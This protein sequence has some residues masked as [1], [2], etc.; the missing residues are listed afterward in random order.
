MSTPD[1]RQTAFPHR[2]QRLDGSASNALAAIE[3]A[4][5]VYAVNPSGPLS[6]LARAPMATAASVLALE[7][8]GLVVR[9]RAMR[10][11]AFV[12]PADVAPLVWAAT[13][14]P[15]ARFGWM[16]KAAGVSPGGFEAAR[17]ALVAA[18][19]EP[20]TAREL[21]GAACLDGVD[22][23]RFVSYLA[24]RGDLT[25][26]GALSVT[27]NVSRYVAREPGPTGAAVPASAR[28]RAPAQAWLAGAYLRSFG[29]ARAEDLAWWAGITRADATAALAAHETVEVEPGLLLHARDLPE[30]EATPPLPGALVLA[31]KWD[32]LTMG[33]PLDGR[34]R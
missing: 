34:A 4:V 23:S 8:D 33:Y 5:G 14:Q 31:P 1:H 20:R 6:I 18:A 30:Y 13:A 26:L 15:L 21:R 25:V 28:D 7:R 19:A 11:S 24:L 3:A 16:L 10:S 12:L 27:S 29:P 22:V 32:A 2:R 17:S 9:G